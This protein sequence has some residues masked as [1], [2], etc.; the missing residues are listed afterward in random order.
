MCSHGFCLHIGAVRPNPLWTEYRD[1]TLDQAPLHDCYALIPFHSY[2]ADLLHV[3]SKC[4]GESLESQSRDNN[5]EKLMVQE[6]K[7]WFS[8]Y[9]VYT[10]N[11]FH[12]FEGLRKWYFAFFHQF[13]E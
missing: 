10:R 9:K 12:D 11:D 13:L 2:G 6:Y 1:Y 5:D 4:I 3:R 8:M 7:L